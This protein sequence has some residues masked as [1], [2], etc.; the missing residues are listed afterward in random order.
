VKRKPGKEVIRMVRMTAARLPPFYLLLFPLQHTLAYVNQ[1]KTLFAWVGY[2][3]IPIINFRMNRMSR[4][5][6][7]ICI[8]TS[9]LN[10]IVTLQKVRRK[11]GLSVLTI[12]SCVQGYTRE[13]VWNPNS[14]KLERGQPPACPPAICVIA[15]Q[16]SSVT[17][18]SLLFHSRQEKCG[19]F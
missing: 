9:R 7:S 19:A 18:M 6:G 13:F 11:S 14:N 8:D 3:V 10:A 4:L 2:H 1:P 17:F 16:Y 15:Q 5:E 12:N